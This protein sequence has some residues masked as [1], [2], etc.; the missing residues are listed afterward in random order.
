MR[1]SNQTTERS[2]KKGVR[3]EEKAR[4]VGGRKTLI[5]IPGSPPTRIMMLSIEIGMSPKVVRGKHRHA[6]LCLYMCQ[7]LKTLMLKSPSLI[8]IWHWRP[9]T[10]EPHRF[11]KSPCPRQVRSDN[12]NK[13]KIANRK[14]ST[15]LVLLEL[16]ANGSN[17]QKA[18]T[19]YKN[20]Q[21]KN[22][23]WIC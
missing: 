23:P 19:T 9:S 16:T 5:T 21:F 2:R 17:D 10:A 3:M 6:S 4:R 1:N 14:K 22:L 13:E 12:M 15:L 11:L 20:G 18:R 7:I 8:N